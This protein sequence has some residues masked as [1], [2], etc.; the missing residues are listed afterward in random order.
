MSDREMF[1]FATNN[2]E[3]RE[4]REA[5]RSI[6]WEKDIE[7]SVSQIDMSSSVGNNYNA[8]NDLSNLQLEETEHLEN[9]LKILTLRKFYVKR[10]VAKSNSRSQLYIVDTNESKRFDKCVLFL[11]HSLICNI[12]LKSTIISV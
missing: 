11:K 1:N 10:T 9:T 4:Y 2:I 6:S 8:P 3:E 12:F 5:I 7:I